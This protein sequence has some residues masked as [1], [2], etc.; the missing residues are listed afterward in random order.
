MIWIIKTFF[1][2]WIVTN[3]YFKQKE[4]K[5][6][7]TR[8]CLFAHK[9]ELS[10]YSSYSPAITKWL[11]HKQRWK[12]A[13]TVHTYSSWMNI[14]ITWKTF[15]KTSSQPQVYWITVSW[16]GLKKSRF[17]KKASQMISMCSKFSNHELHT[18]SKSGRLQYFF[19]NM[20]QTTF[21]WMSKPKIVAKLTGL[22]HMYFVLWSMWIERLYVSCW[23]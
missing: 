22:F 23:E 17:K 3:I 5:L 6:V 7:I 10:R 13:Q 19:E 9:Q 21:S 4:N 11:H 14:K 20:N 16:Y 18:P 2:S 8:G 1:C 15:A 12:L